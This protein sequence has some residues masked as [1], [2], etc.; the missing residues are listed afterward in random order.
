MFK[1]KK[2]D[3]PAEIC[4]GDESQSSPEV[5]KPEA[6]FPIVG[7][8]A[9][10]GGLEALE[11]FI[12][13]IPKDSGMSFVIVQHLDPTRKDLMVEL[14]Q[15]VT[16]MQVMQVAEHTVVQPNCIYM[17]PPNKDMS[18]FHGTLH[19]FAP[20]EPRGLRLPIDYFFRSLA[21]DKQEQSMGVILSGMGSD[22]TLGLGAIKEKGGVVF[23]Q[24]PSTAKFSSMPKSVIEAGLADVIAPAEELAP[25]ILS[26]HQHKPSFDSPEP[27]LTDKT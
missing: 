13:N 3:S 21:D 18:I 5:E 27:A 26:Y 8:G 10:A 1:K 14:L 12:K 16:S 9:S 15:R 6:S 23:V 25:K 7:I 22:G 4:P 11:L 19:L 17:I 2:T 20:A 24:E